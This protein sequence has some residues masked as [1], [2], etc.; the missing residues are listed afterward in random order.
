MGGW[1][2]DTEKVGVWGCPQGHLLQTRAAGV[3][4]SARGQTS[5][6]SAVLSG[7]W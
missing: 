4:V 1:E 2:L 6:P 3:S 7:E 5:V